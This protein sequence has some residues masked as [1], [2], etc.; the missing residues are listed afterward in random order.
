MSFAKN[1]KYKLRRKF[2][3]KFKQQQCKDFIQRR[4]EVY[5]INNKSSEYDDIK[6]KKLRHFSDEYPDPF[7]TASVIRT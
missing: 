5:N 4:N 7:F 6:V 3:P 2:S 1:I